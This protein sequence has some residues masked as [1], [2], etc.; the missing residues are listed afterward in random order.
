LGVPNRRAQVCTA[1]I[2]KSATKR[3]RTRILLPAAKFYRW[4]PITVGTAETVANEIERKRWLEGDAPE[5]LIETLN[6]RFLWLNLT[7]VNGLCLCH[8]AVE[9]PQ[10]YQEPLMPGGL[11]EMDLEVRPDHLVSGEHYQVMTEMIESE[12]VN[13]HHVSELLS[14]QVQ[15]F[16]SERED[17]LGESELARLLL[18]AR[19]WMSDGSC[20][21]I[22]ASSESMADALSDFQLDAGDGL[23]RL[24]GPDQGYLSYAVSLGRVAALELPAARLSSSKR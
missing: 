17:V 19:V 4:Y 7:I 12:E 6:N 3:I 16:L 18:H 21:W 23:L 5:L 8:D 1:I 9:W 15:A 2:N 14:H 22:D 10:P 24:E 13:P 20:Q 11:A